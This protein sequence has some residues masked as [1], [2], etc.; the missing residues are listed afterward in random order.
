MQHFP[1][2]YGCFIKSHLPENTSHP[3]NYLN[4]NDTRFQRQLPCCYHCIGDDIQYMS[5]ILLIIPI[6]FQPRF[7]PAIYLL[8]PGVSRRLNS[9]ANITSKV[10]L[11]PDPV[12][13]NGDSTRL[14]LF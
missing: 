6:M 10:T 12:C 11:T 4:R 7:Y 3:N 14:H 5:L 13:H 8:Y 1:Y 9:R 2:Y